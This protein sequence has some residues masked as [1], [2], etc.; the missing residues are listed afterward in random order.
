MSAHGRA[1]YCS[2]SINVYS[3]VLSNPAANHEFAEFFRNKIRSIVDDPQTAAD[4][5]PTDYPSATKRPCL[6]TNYYAT[7]N[8]PHVRLVNVRKHPIR[9]D[10]RN[11]HRYRRRVFI[12]DAIVFATGFDAV[13]GALTAV[14]ITGP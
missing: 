2:R 10:H 8:L 1:A 11:R 4:L 3:D 5:C 9:Q 14:D 12:F 6:D 7:Y 13:T